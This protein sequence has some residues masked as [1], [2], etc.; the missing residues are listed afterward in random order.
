VQVGARRRG[1][2]SGR[3]RVVFAAAVACGAAALAVQGAAAYRTD[4]AVRLRVGPTRLLSPSFGYTVAYRAVERNHRVQT[5]VGVFVYDHCRWRDVTPPGL[6]ADEI[7]DVAFVDPRHGWIAAYD[8]AKVKVSL[9]RTSNGGRTWLPLGAPAEHSCGGGPTWLSFADREHGWME[10][11]SPN[12]PQGDLLETSDG[13]GTWTRV[14]TLDDALPCLA[15]IVF[16]SPSAGWMGRCDAHVYSTSDGGRH[17]RRATIRVSGAPK[18]RQFDVPRFFGEPGIQAATLGDAVGT[19]QGGLRERA[20]AFSVSTDGGRSWSQRSLRPIAPCTQS[21]G[22]FYPSSWPAAVAGAGVW[23]IVT[24]GRHPTVQRTDDGG[25][26][27]HTTVARGLA[28]G[29]CG[30]L[31]VSAASSTVAWA[32]TRAG[33]GDSRLF[34]TTDGGRSWH[35]VT[36][37]R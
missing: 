9:Y 18:V 7:D 23:W 16:V 37:L 4:T 10:P 31:S 26:S 12:G 36:L 34:R 35:H 28:S 24:T 13:G 2:G 5:A 17:W 14:A 1:S 33:T 20:V 25:R 15:P 22:L 30:L 27:W 32:V 3:C 8:C 29:P 21:G 6:H 11:V 19:G